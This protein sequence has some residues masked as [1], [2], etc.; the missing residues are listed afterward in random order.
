MSWRSILKV[1]NFIYD[2]R[3]DAPAGFYN[4]ETDEVTLNLG[5]MNNLSEDAMIDRITNIAFHEYS[6]KAVHNSI[7]PLYR[8]LT[9]AYVDAI[10]E[11]I[12]SIE[13]DMDRLK[14]IVKSIG[15]V[16]A[17][18]ESFAYASQYNMDE[19]QNINVDASTI[20]SLMNT[21]TEISKQILT[22]ARMQEPELVDDIIHN[23]NFVGN[24][25][26]KETVKVSVEMENLV[27]QF[28]AQNPT[29]PEKRKELLDSVEKNIKRLNKFLKG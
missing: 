4:P 24:E 7:R 18:D 5:Q 26:K 22:I 12:F 8:K 10:P 19:N 21:F 11:Y 3:E 9:K 2:D 15:Q 6:H 17:M 16:I 20:T 23:I 14:N 13:T 27:R 25:I 29:N 1:D 28:L